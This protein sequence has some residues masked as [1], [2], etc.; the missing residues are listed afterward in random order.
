MFAWLH[1]KPAPASEEKLR[2]LDALVDYPPYAPPIWNSDAKSAQD[3]NDEYTLCF[4]EN[5]SR[6]LEALRNFLPKFDV[7]LS[8]EDAGV[9]AVSAWC[10]TYA[11]LL[12]DGLQ[13]QES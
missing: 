9:K 12:V 2:L 8:L 4:L 6:R 1:R 3:A 13:H 5:R 11:D 7:A 10:A